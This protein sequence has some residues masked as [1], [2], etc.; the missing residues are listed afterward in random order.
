MTRTY[1]L[2][3]YFRSSCSA[4]VRIAAHLKGIELEYKYI[5]LLKNDHHSD[6][7]T[8]LNPSRSVPTLIVSENGEEEFVIRQSVAILEYF[9]EAFPDTP[10]LLPPPA[11]LAA[12]AKVRDLVNIIACDLQPVTNLRIIQ[13]IRPTGIDA[14]EWQQHFMS[15]GLRAYEMLVSRYAGK[16]SVGDSV[17]LADVTLAPAIDNALR[18]G[19]DLDQFPVISRLAQE[20]DQVY[21]FQKGNW[22]TQPDTPEE[23]RKS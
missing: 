17:T 22:K 16:Y 6:T 10:R 1:T 21:A 9:E 19:V 5:H 13:R 18:Y 2:Y 7:Y 15:A 4:R 8:S 3:T 20:F 12:R 23:L 14:N 11:D